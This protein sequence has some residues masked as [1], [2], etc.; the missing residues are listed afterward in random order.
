MLAQAHCPA[1]AASVAL[2]PILDLLR[3]LFGIDAGE[4]PDASRRKIRRSLLQ[5]SRSFADALPFAFDLLQ[6]PDPD[7]PV[8]LLDEQRRA[9]LVD[10]LRRLVQA[11]SAAAPLVLFIDDVHWIDPDGDALLG[12]IV[13]ALGWTH[14]LLLVNFRPG[15]RVRLDARLVLPGDVARRAVRRRGRRAAAPSD[16]RRSRRPTICGG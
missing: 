9:R 7:R 13:D 4:P 2:L 11:Q 14:T 8:Q 1:H 6:V 12:E 5:L 15:Y 3:S 16:R 10:F